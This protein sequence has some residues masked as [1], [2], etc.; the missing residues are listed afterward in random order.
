MSEFSHLPPE[1][2]DDDMVDSNAY[3]YGDA[4]NSGQY[5]IVAPDT[6][7]ETGISASQ[8]ES[9][10][11]ATYDDGLLPPLPPHIRDE[12]ITARPFL[13]FRQVFDGSQPEIPVQEQIDAG[14]VFA[15]FVDNQLEGRD[16]IGFGVQDGSSIVKA[17][18]EHRDEYGIRER[19]LR[20]KGVDFTDDG[21]RWTGHI[22]IYRLDLDG[23]VRRSDSQPLTQDEYE[24]WLADLDEP[25]LDDD[26]GVPSN[27]MI[28]D[29]IE[30]LQRKIAAID[31][32]QELGFQNQPV[33]PAE[34]AALIRLLQTK[35]L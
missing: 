35:R 4:I 16:A 20:V 34:I 19:R 18:I 23:V 2:D 14:T 28:D 26:F 7:D 33:G 8:A 15:D 10:N 9:L 24:E 22:A 25:E 30:D 29:A 5:E 27:E 3:G 13:A 32:A 6:D 21:P 17:M 12:R 1:G 31:I 11:I